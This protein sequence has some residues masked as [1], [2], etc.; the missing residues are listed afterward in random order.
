VN[1]P[2]TPY[3]GAQAMAGELDSAVLLTWQGEGHT[4][5]PKTPCITRAVDAYLLQLTVPTD[6]S[7][8]AG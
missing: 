1:D 2:A 8:P 5:Y 6:D 3:S 4:A 7:C